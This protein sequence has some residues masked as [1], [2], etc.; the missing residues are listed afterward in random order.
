[1]KL[2]LY[3]SPF[4][5]TLDFPQRGKSRSVHLLALPLGETGGNRARSHL[6]RA[7]QGDEC[8]GNLDG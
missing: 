5:A 7:A 8:Y 4:A 6:Q 3:S 1:M 2:P